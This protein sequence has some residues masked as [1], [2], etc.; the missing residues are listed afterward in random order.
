[1]LF[2]RTE[3][4]TGIHLK[5]SPGQL[6]HRQCDQAGNKRSPLQEAR[7]GRESKLD[8]ICADSVMCSVITY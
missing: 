8:Q 4:S 1:M 2:G 5:F 6:A 7:T 3:R